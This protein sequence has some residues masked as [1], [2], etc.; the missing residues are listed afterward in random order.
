MTLTL[1]GAASRRS[2]PF[3]AFGTAR[4]ATG[5]A[6]NIPRLHLALFNSG[7]RPR[8]ERTLVSLRPGSSDA[9][10]RLA[11][12]LRGVGL[13]VAV[14]DVA[15]A[16]GLDVLSALVVDGAHVRL[17]DGR[18]LTPDELSRELR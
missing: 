3:A 1:P 12:A 17:A 4:P 13:K 18:V 5:F 8:H 7:W 9:T 15:E 6:I 10:A 11:G 2:V 16:A 14:G